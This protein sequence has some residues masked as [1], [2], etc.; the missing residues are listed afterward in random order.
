MIF[1]SP[2]NLASIADDYVVGTG[3]A[4][5][6][7]SI[8]GAGT[9]VAGAV[10]A[11]HASGHAADLQAKAADDALAFEKAQE[12]K[13]RA[14]YLEERQRA[15]D[16]QDTD[17]AR[18][19]AAVDPFINFGKQGLEPLSSLL[20]PNAGTNSANWHVAPSTT[21]PPTSGRPI[22]A[23]AAGPGTSPRPGAATPPSGQGPISALTQ[24]GGPI[25]NG[26]DPTAPVQGTPVPAP[27][28]SM[29]NSQ[30]VNPVVYYRSLADLGRYGRRPMAATS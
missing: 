4:L 6:V 14:Q 19:Q 24:Y 5:L 17:R 13:D 8:I 27:P 23:M 16:Q 25:T 29:P 28:V 20:K 12:E 7:G 21:Q 11:S 3:I 26:P 10:K 1:H 30:P 15:W 9:G 18:H 2:D 22:A